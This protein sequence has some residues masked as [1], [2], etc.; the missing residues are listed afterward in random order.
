MVIEPRKKEEPNVNERM[1]K[2]GRMKTEKE[3]KGN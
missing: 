3:R 2:Y 1:E